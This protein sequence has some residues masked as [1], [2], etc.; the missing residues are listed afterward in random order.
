VEAAREGVAGLAMAVSRFSAPEGYVETRWFDPRTKQ[1]H[2][3][4]NDP[5]HLVRL[6]VWT[7]LVTP[8]ET[9]IVVETVHRTTTDPSVPDR[10]VEV[11]ADSSSA[12]DS[13]TRALAAFV[14]QRFA[15]AKPD[16]MRPATP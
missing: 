15:S 11:V 9:Q 1:S 10:E 6:R 13:L 14:R 12:G 7:D 3:E 2:R 4:N 5:Q 8:R 16:S